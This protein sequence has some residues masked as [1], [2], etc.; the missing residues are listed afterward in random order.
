VNLKGKRELLRNL[1][2]AFDA[3][4]ETDYLWDVG[5]ATDRELL[6]AQNKLYN[7]ISLIKDKM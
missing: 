3:Y 1:A 5:K 2:K 7:M 6:E 4:I